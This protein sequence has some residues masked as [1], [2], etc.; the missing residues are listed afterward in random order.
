M[1]SCLPVCLFKNIIEEKMTV[2]DWVTAAKKMGFDA[3]DLSILFIK[4]RTPMGIKK[5]REQL[6]RSGLPVAMIACYPDFTQPDEKLRE[7]ELM[8]AYSDIAVAAALG[9][10]YLRITA[11]QIY[12]NM[13]EE[14]TYK[15]VV[16][17]FESCVKKAE[18]FGISLLLENHAKPGAWERHDFDFK[19]SRFLKLV[20]LTE[21]LPLWI[22]FDTANTYAYGDNAP[23]IFE[24]V[25]KRVRSI[26]I[27][28]IRDVS[29]LEFV[30]IGEGTAPIKEIFKIAK[31]NKFDGL[32]SIEEAGNQGLEGVEQSFIRAKKLWEEA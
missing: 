16:E 29:K 4:N 7:Y 30:S 23:L 10:K 24:K 6:Q 5:I 2:E 26:H 17:C 25:Y 28:D 22:N 27:N 18:K 12:E 8:H 1:W 31:A 32:L 3:A 20:E 13:D 19:T 11:G 14:K 9:A 21:H 15:N